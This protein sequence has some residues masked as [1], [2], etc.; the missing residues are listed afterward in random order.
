[1]LD[2]AEIRRLDA[3]L[4]FEVIDTAPEPGFDRIVNLAVRIFGAEVALVCLIDE[5][6]V[7]YKAKAGTGSNEQPRAGSFCSQAIR[8]PDVLVVEDT[9]AGPW[10]GGAGPLGEA[11]GFY[12]G[13][14]LT[15][16][17]GEH[18]G[19][20]CVMDRRSRPFSDDD[21]TALSDLAAIV[22]EEL[23]HRRRSIAFARLNQRS[24]RTDAM[25]HA[26]ADAATCEQALA[27]LLTRLCDDHGAAAGHIWRLTLPDQV[28]RQVS[29]NPGNR[30][31][32]DEHFELARRLGAKP[33]NSLTADTIISGKPRAVRF[34]GV[35]DL[36]RYPMLASAMRHG[37]M[38]QVIQPL[39]VAGEQF[40]ITLFFDTDR[41]DLDLV[42][43]DVGMLADTIRPALYRKVAE[44]R[45][46]LL[47][48]A[49][50]RANDSVMITEA[51]PHDPLG[52]RI[53]YVNSSFCR[54]TGYAAHEVVG[55]SPRLLLGP[56]ADLLAQGQF[57][58]AMQEGTP[59]RTEIEHCRKDGSRF[60][61]E[62]DVTPLADATGW[63]TLWISIQ[64]DITRRRQTD[65]ARRE[66]EASNRTLFEQSPMPTLVFDRHSLRFLDVN[67]AAVS[68]YGWSRAQFLAM[69]LPDLLAADE[70]PTFGTL[71]A[72]N[73]VND[74]A[75][76]RW[77]HLRADGS[78]MEVTVA[79][80]ALT[81]A[82]EDA[83]MAVLQDVTEVEAAKRAMQEANLRLEDLARQLQART[84][85]LTEVHRLAR[86]GAWRRSLD[87]S[88]VMWSDE[89]F[90]IT[91]F[92][93]SEG[94]PS[95]KATLARVHPDDQASLR[96][97]QNNAATMRSASVLDFRIVLP[98]GGVRHCRLD[99][100]PLLGAAGTVTGLY[101]YCQDITEHKQTELALLRSE[102]LKSIGQLTGGIAHD[103]NNLLT[104]VT[105]NLEEAL[106][107]MPEGEPLR[108]VL[109]PAMHAAVRGA[110]LTKQLLSYARRAA[111]RPERVR[112]AGFFEN[113]RPLLTRTIGKR[114]DLRLEA[115]DD[116]T[117]FTDPAQLENAIINLVINARDA[118]PDGGCI[119]VSTSLATVAAADVLPGRAGH[120]VPDDLA[121]GRYLRISVAD[122]GTGIPPELLAQVFEPFFTTKDVGRG[123][124][125]GLSMVYGFA[126]QS[127]GQA[128]IS[129]ELG[130]GTTVR[131]FLPVV[132]PKGEAAP[133]LPIPAW[134]NRGLRALVVDDEPDVL[135]TAARMVSNMG[136]EVTTALSAADA[137]TWMRESEG[138]DLLFSDVRLPGPV[139]GVALAAQARAQVPGISVLL[140]SG[141]TDHWAAAL[142]GT[143]AGLPGDTR[144]LAKPYTRQALHDALT[145]LLGQE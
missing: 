75:R 24:A 99:A 60:W 54:A 38:C 86:L 11:C 39:R 117:A 42:L 25:T 89:M 72:G 102:K 136:L 2:I 110:E 67:G 80:H 131:L 84:A 116:G 139:D 83:V 123:S 1:M 15:A 40:G 66:R 35:A 70:Q 3:L 50:D 20:L 82:G 62:M 132:G 52:P 13:A 46:H 144:F 74:I 101:G 119:R 90:E 22:S 45:M 118:M 23:Q 108:D 61:V 78:R 137:A 98:G 103:F 28:L 81:Y 31:Q 124:G 16:A 44:E 138:F 5:H 93:Q 145:A 130:A 57:A 106:D 142:D 76:R 56:D 53:A 34:A 30:V 8:S 122:T 59:T 85:Q 104:V 12:A 92:P 113:L 128:T 43:E 9:Q 111:L 71:I 48:T 87:G 32:M 21:K 47:S 94:I 114:Y 135:A 79:S 91:G 51:P 140:T 105:L 6:R 97:V 10:H 125:L 100:R 133:P 55:Q 4:S 58:R 134:Q 120:D 63:Q 141:Y 88:D 7:W 112:L 49:L 73:Q 96:L 37:M 68:Q 27:G 95:M 19:T 69:S 109:Q 17:H 14:P 18:V 36:H 126:K 121:P 127:G 77:T 115:H 64:R 65:Q 129:S 33:G 107:T 41:T 26:V 29:R 143:G